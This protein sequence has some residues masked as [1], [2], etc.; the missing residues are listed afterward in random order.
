MELPIVMVEA[1]KAARFEERLN[2]A[3]EMAEAVKTWNETAICIAIAAFVAGCFAGG[4]I[5]SHRSEK[6]R[7]S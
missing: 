4:W 3:V 7:V 1:I 6:E 5:V 2:A